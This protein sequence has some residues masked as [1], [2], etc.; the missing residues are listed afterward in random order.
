M[1]M[2]KTEA[3]CRMVIHTN[4]A[5]HFGQTATIYNNEYREH[6]RHSWSYHS[7]L[8]G[9]GVQ[10]AIRRIDKELDISIHMVVEG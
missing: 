7:L 9:H 4:A 8:R 2:T 6:E 5:D 10:E 1:N 3:R